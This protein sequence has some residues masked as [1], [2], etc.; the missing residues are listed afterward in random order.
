MP[1][2]NHIQYAS[3]ILTTKDW[4]FCMFRWILSVICDSYNSCL[5]QALHFFHIYIFPPWA[6]IPPKYCHPSADSFDLVIRLQRIEWFY[7]YYWEEKKY[8]PGTLN[9]LWI[10]WWNSWQKISAD[11][12]STIIFQT[13]N[14]ISTE[15]SSTIVFPFPIDTLCLSVGD[16]EKEK[17]EKKENWLNSVHLL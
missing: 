3:L 11:W 9:A 14:A 10:S 16:K 5:I 8:V 17:K 1:L 13:L 4:L 6:G 7:G 2:I 12:L 15:Q